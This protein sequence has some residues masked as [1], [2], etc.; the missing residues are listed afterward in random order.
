M[1]IRFYMLQAH[2]SSPVDFSNDSLKAAEQGLTRL[3]KGIALIQKL[4]PAERSTANISEMVEN[5]Y[6]AMSD[7]LNTPVVISHLFEA[8]RVIHSVNEGKSSLNEEDLK[9]LRDIMNL[10]TY[11]LLGLKNEETENSGHS[12]LLNDVIN[13]LLQQRQEAKLRKD[14]A[15]SDNIRNQLIALGIAIKDTKEGTEWEIN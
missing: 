10:F 15:A 12:K 6:T 2:Y 8:V 9:T 13:I 11:D 7:D 4:K 14:Y 5:L 3:M 1:T